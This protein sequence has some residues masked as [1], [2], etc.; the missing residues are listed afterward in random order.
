[1]KNNKK[2]HCDTVREWKEDY[3]KYLCRLKPDEGTPWE[4]CD[5]DPNQVYLI[6]YRKIKKKKNDGD[7]ICGK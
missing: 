5:Y 1:M 2:E 6:Q 4:L 7:K 3:Q